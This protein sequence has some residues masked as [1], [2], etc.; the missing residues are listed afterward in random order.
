MLRRNIFVPIKNQFES[1]IITSSFY[2]ATV[3]IGY[4]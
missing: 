2:I 3:I 4:F 1:R